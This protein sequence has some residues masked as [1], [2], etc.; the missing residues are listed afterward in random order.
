MLASQ[1]SGSSANSAV[2]GPPPAMNAQLTPGGAQLD[3]LTG[4]RT[5]Q[6]QRAMEAIRNGG[7]GGTGRLRPR[8]G[9]RPQG[10]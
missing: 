3:W 1:T 9:V 5:E 7:N 10:Q 4:V 2:G 8:E 6:G